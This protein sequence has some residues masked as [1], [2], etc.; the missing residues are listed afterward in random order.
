MN[1]RFILTATT[2][3]TMGSAAFA[4]ET[5]TI[6]SSGGALGDGVIKAFIEPFEKESGI[7]VKIVKD[8]ASPAQLMLK[9]QAGN[10]DVDVAG[11]P[12]GDAFL[13]LGKD[14]LE[15]ID[16]AKLDAD[17]M[18]KLPEG[19]KQPWGVQSFSYAWVL[20]VDTNRYPD[21]TGPQSWADLWDVEKFP[22]T[23]VMESAELGSQGP[24]EE[25]L[26]AD[27]VPMEELY[28]LDVDRAFA[29]LDRIKPHIRKWWKVGSEQ[30]Q[31]FQGGAITM[32]QGFDGRFNALIAEGKPIAVNYNQAKVTGFYWTIP[33][34]AKNPDAAHKFIE[35]ASRPENQ[36]V[37]A[38][39]TGYGPSNPD[40]FEHLDPE[41]AKTLITYPDNLANSYELNAAWFAEVG[42]DG[43]T[44]AD[45]IAERWNM[46]I[47]Q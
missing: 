20:G 7:T 44:N 25:A 24:L 23:R 11:I 39:M 27:G 2:C 17:L 16:Y 43:K 34:G 30:M 37:F 32:G 5:V 21:G 18:A 31:L 47:I 33:K 35:F 9:A 19:A 28:P 42:E 13:M 1:I 15:S 4:Q 46:W 10:M 14:A 22:G 26:L 8:Q 12:P 45:R 41:F 6:I 36:A 38:Q 40:T 29:S 3:L